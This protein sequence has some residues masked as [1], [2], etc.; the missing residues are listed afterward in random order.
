[1]TD[2]PHIE[3]FRMFRRTY[4]AFTPEDMDAVAEMFAEDV[5]WHTPDRKPLSG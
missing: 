3:M 5:V 4:A 2:H 1:M